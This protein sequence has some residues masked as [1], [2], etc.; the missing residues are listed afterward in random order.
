MKKYRICRRYYPFA[1]TWYV[2]QK[3]IFFFWWRTYNI[4]FENIR[5][6]NNLL[7]DIECNKNDTI[8][9]TPLIWNGEDFIEKYPCITNSIKL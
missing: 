9:E 4:S 2:I 1:G 7:K 3:R 5:D 8:C 6:A